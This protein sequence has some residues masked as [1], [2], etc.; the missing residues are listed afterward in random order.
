VSAFRLC[1]IVP[2]FDNPRTVGAVVERLAPHVDQ[3][4]VVDDGSGAEG[5][6]AVA[7]LGER[8]LAI[9]ARLP[10]NSGKGAAVKEGLALARARGFTHA[11]QVDADG[12][13]E[14][15]DVPA[16]VEAARAAPEA[17]VL[18]QPVFDAS[19]PRAR[20]WARKLTVF[21]THVETLGRVI[22]DPMCGFRIYPLSAF[23]SVACAG[24]RMD[25]DIEVAVRLA[26]SG[27]RIINLPTRVRYVPADEGGVSHFR[28]LG[29]NLRISLMHTRLVFLM[30]AGLF[31]GLP[32]RLA[33][34]RAR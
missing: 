25:F 10:R 31:G 29:D 32:A 15:G 26:W 27:R 9:V 22:A 5:A 30:L 12:Q 16:F 8:G 17:V 20:L 19:A 11:L 28:L 7:S 34:G 6:R 3:V 18:G 23:D 2:T 14:L 4:L 1:A 21:W 33:E 13:H 24:D